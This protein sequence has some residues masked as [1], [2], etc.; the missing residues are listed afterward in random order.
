MLISLCGLIV[1]F[2]ID[3]EHPL[4]TFSPRTSTSFMVLKVV[5]MLQCLQTK[6]EELDVNE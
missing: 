5:S 1:M 4:K 6:K 3:I 2:Q